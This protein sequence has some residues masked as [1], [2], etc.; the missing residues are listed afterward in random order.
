[1]LS[2][3]PS[4]DMEASAFPVSVR[5]QLVVEVEVLLFQSKVRCMG[6]KGIPESD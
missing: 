5:D 2:V 3:C 4:S 6:V 1:M